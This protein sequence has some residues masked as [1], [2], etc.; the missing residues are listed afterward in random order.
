M[1][2]FIEMLKAV[3]MG[4]IEGITEWLPISSTGHMIILEEW[5]NIKGSQGEAFFNLFLVVIQFGAILAVIIGFFKKLWP[6]GKNKSPEEKKKIWKMWL[7]ILLASL[8]ALIVG[9][10][11]DDFLDSH[12]YNFLTVSITLCVYGIAFILVEFL[13]NKKSA[14]LKEGEEMFKTNDIYLLTWQQALIIGCAQVLALIPGTSRSGVT[15]IAALLLSCSREV[16]AEFSFYLAIPAMVGGSL[17]K[18]VKFISAGNKLTST[19]WGMIVLGC[20]VALAVSLLTIRF[21]VKFI[22]NHTFTG[23]GIYRVAF[24][25]LLLVLYLSVF[26]NQAAASSSSASCLFS[27]NYSFLSGLTEN[28]LPGGLK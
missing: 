19:Q 7:C 3:L 13:L 15:I 6:F 9:L 28:L 11:L 4:L 17:I 16:A 18:S 21:F 25:L 10:P 23:F 8:P 24:G 14:S 2:T 12:L 20:V 1:Q 22:K 27:D 26:K 5:L